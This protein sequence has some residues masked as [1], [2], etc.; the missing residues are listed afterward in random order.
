[1]LVSVLVVGIRPPV[2]FT[3]VEPPLV[4]TFQMLPAGTLVATPGPAGVALLRTK[5]E[6]EYSYFQAREATISTWPSQVHPST[7]SCGVLNTI[8]PAANGP[9]GTIVM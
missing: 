1:M 3:P 7:C 4:P 8:G 2:V 9:F 5:S 6:A